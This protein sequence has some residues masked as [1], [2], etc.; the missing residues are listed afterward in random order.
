MLCSPRARQGNFE[1]FGGVRSCLAPTNL[2]MR[3][4]RPASTS[5]L[6][7]NV[8]LASR[9]P[10]VSPDSTFALLAEVDQSISK[11]ETYREVA[12]QQSPQ[13]DHCQIR[14]QC[15]VSSLQLVACVGRQRLQ[16]F[17]QPLNVLGRERPVDTSALPATCANKIVRGKRD[18]ESD[19]HHSRVVVRHQR[20][21]PR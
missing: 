18:I 12:H 10:L 21:S 6:R 9:S 15:W 20:G 3:P 2:T 19:I 1:R 4:S 8:P 11:K 17:R 7:G 5:G 14:T 16:G 13:T